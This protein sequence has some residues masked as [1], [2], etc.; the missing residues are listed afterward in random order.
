MLIPDRD[1]HYEPWTESEPTA[2]IHGSDIWH[3][4]NESVRVPN[5]VTLACTGRSVQRVRVTVDA[6][7]LSLTCKRCAK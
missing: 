5:Y 7:G 6:Y 1:G 3:K 2:R 4:I